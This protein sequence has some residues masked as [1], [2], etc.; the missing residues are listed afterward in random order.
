MCA[1]VSS[2]GGHCK[3]GHDL[4]AGQQRSTPALGTL[5]TME[6]CQTILSMHVMITNEEKRRSIMGI[7]GETG[8]IEM[9]G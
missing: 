2:H 4:V 9:L 7:S 6:V 8:A 5:S 3:T 1:N